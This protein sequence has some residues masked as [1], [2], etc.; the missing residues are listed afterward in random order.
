MDF[1]ELSSISYGDFIR[2]LTYV[3]YFMKRV[4]KI[5]ISLV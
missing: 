4:K 1:S 3:K 2:I 5:T